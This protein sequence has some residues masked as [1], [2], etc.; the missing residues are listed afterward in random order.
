M[1]IIKRIKLPGWIVLILFFTFLIGTIHH[2]T[3]TRT[4]TYNENIN[5]LHQTA[6]NQKIIQEEIQDTEEAVIQ[7]EETEDI[8]QAV[9]QK[10]E[11]EDIQQ[12]VIQKEETDD[13]QQV[14]IQKEEI[15]DIQQAVIQKEEIEDIQQVVIQKEET[16]DIQQV[17]IQ[18]EEIEDQVKLTKPQELDPSGKY[19]AFTFDDGP[20]PNVTPRILQIL[21]E[22]NIRATFFMLGSQVKKYSNIAKQVADNG[23]EIGNHTYSHPNLKKLTTK[24]I[25]EEIHSTNEII[26]LTTGIEP[27]LFRPPYGNYT[28][29]VLEYTKTNGY[30]TI[31]WSVD[32]LDWKS[33]NA[34][35]INRMVTQHTTNGSIVLMHDIHVATA[36]ALPQLIQ[37][38][39]TKGYQFVTVSELLSIRSKSSNGVY[40]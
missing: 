34:S 40:F 4:E 27:T 9:F 31:L 3:N 8:Q 39:Q 15:E 38:L 22:Y 13:I 29:E 35:A 1:G 25:I 33:R 23:H 21:K 14:V 24:R 11:T 36:D 5:S 37:T 28:N 30:S 2:F 32:S 12:V 20:H 18:K 17:V 6:N 26:T 19:V 7:K 16:E 10:E